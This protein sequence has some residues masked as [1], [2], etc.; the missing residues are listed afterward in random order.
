MKKGI[1]FII[2]IVAICVSLLSTQASNIGNKFNN[3]FVL[4]NPQEELTIS[5]IEPDFAMQGSETEL[6][7]VG[8]GFNN[9][10]GVGFEP[11]GGLLIKNVKFVAIGEIR[12]DIKVDDYAACGKRDVIVSS[13]D[14]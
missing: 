4:E 12:V 11:I 14:G 6:R 9:S 1:F 2:F 5:K 8:T 7:I 13:Q 10:T 3:V